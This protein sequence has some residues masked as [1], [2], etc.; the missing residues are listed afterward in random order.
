MIRSL[1]FAIAAVF[2]L[3]VQAVAA[4]QTPEI[5]VDFKDEPVTV[6][7]EFI[8]RITVLVPTFMPK[9][10]VFPTFEATNI[11]VRLPEKSSTPTSETINGETWSGITRA[12]RLYPMEAG[13]TVIPP[14][15]VTLFYSNTSDSTKLETYTVQTPEFK[16]VASL[17]EKAMDLDP[18][19]LATGLTVSQ[20]LIP[21]EGPLKVGDSIERK[22]SI[23]ID[24]TSPLFIPPLLTTEQIDGLTAYP[25]DPKVS[26]TSNRGLMSGTR[27][28][29]VVYVAQTAG[30][31]VLPD[32][33]VSW[34][35]IETDTVETVTLPGLTT[36]ITQ[37]NVVVQSIKKNLMGTV[38]AVIVAALLAWLV[39]TRFLRSRLQ[40]LQQRLSDNYAK[41]AHAQYGHALAAAQAKDLGR[42][43]SESETIPA[44]SPLIEAD[45]LHLA[46]SRYG[47]NATTNTSNDPA[48]A[49]ISQTIKR[50]RPRRTLTEI[51]GRKTTKS[52]EVGDGFG[53]QAK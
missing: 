10:P 29:S 46:H 31:A 16:I 36:E 37:P 26:E 6:G 5:R 4:A 50:Q 42:L 34:Y 40:K 51:L 24:G 14:Q 25:K 30:T 15:D 23:K 28:E 9:P 20:T 17:P 35:N 21:Q 44:L 19:L 53:N 41:S 49:K 45:L 38:I 32:I 13:T 48:W 3:F 1:S 52:F 47:P 27:E 2:L 39:W 43:Y 7:Q 12:Y 8:L 11:I 22:L 33:T 18:P